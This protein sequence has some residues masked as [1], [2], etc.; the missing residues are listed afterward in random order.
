MFFF[1]LQ[2]YL[3]IDNIKNNPG[4]ISVYN[5]DYIKFW[6][7]SF[8]CFSDDVNYNF[9]D[10][11]DFLSF[12]QNKQKSV[13]SSG[14]PSIINNFGSETNFSIHNLNYCFLSF[15]LKYF[16]FLFLFFKNSGIY[17]NNIM[18]TTISSFAHLFQN[19]STINL[20]SSFLPK[21][22][23]LLFYNFYFKVRSLYLLSFNK[24]FSLD[25]FLKYVVNQLFF[26]FKINYR[27]LTKKIRKILKNKYRYKSYPTYI[28]P[29]M[30]VKE[31]LRFLKKCIEL[32]VSDS[33]RDNMYQSLFS[34]IFE[35]N[36][37]W[38][39]K[40]RNKQQLSVLKSFSK[41]K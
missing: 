1:Y 24:F 5:T 33:I 26:F 25:F 3:N 28:K 11:L 38:I 9:E 29:A 18:D 10:N 34:I 19:M 2:N 8:Y 37:S 6:E 32:E 41:T 12:F 15:H 20:K 39:I 30:R 22:V 31:T 14:I 23:L 17:S 36:D 27:A 16:N 4:N 21:S 7:K 13:I 35:D 40:L